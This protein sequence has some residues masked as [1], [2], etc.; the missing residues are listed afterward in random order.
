VQDYVDILHKMNF[1]DVEGHLL[2][3]RTGEVVSVNHG[4]IKTS[5][6]VKDENQLG[7]FSFGE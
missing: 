7:L 1:V 3:I 4:K 6:K 2:Y 5:R